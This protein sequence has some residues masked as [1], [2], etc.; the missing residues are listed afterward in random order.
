MKKIILISFGLFISASSLG[1]EVSYFVSESTKENNYPFS[2]A[3][4]VGDIVYLSGVVGEGEFGLV[5]GGIVPEAHQA[6]K[7]MQETLSNLGLSLDNVFKCLVMIDDIEKWSQ[8]NSVY[9]QYFNKPYPARSAFGADG[10]A[11]NASFEMECIA[12]ISNDH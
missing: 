2:D 11:L 10:L 1:D 7:N 6:L 3:V 8:F 9:I 12:K 4:T 5:V